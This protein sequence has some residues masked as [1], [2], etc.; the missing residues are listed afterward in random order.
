MNVEVVLHLQ[1]NLEEVE[2]ELMVEEDVT[3]EMNQ[4]EIVE[5]ELIVQ[6]ELV[7]HVIQVNQ[8]VIV[9][10]RIQRPIR[11][12]EVGTLLAVKTQGPNK[13]LE[14]QPHDAIYFILVIYYFD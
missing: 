11:N 12:N 13:K 1:D 9:I 5:A 14:I 7:V 6:E 8:M 2:E 4:E 10:Q 3:V